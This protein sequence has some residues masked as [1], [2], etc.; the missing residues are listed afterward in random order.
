MIEPQTKDG[1]DPSALTPPL[2][3]RNY[4]RLFRSALPCFQII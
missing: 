2:R 1:R 3:V 4:L